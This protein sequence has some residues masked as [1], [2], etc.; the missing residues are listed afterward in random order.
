MG[1]ASGEASLPGQSGNVETE[2]RDGASDARDTLTRTIEEGIAG[3]IEEAMLEPTT[4]I[5]SSSMIALV[6]ERRHLLN[7]AVNNRKCRYRE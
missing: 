6:A 5:H 3:T 7:A 2:L 4:Q 1:E